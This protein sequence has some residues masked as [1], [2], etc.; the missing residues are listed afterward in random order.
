[1]EKNY[2]EETKVINKLNRIKQPTNIAFNAILLFFAL[3]CFLPFIVVVLISVTEEESIRQY[4]YQLFPKV[5][6]GQAYRFLWNERSQILNALSMSLIVTAI[7]TVVGVLL[8]TVL[9]YV[10][11]RPD[12]KLKGFLTWM[13]F[14]PMIF[15]GGMVASYV[16]NVQLLQVRNG[17]HA[18]ILPLLVSSVIVV[19][20]RTFFRTTIPDS[21][22]ESAKID[23]AGQLLIY[24]KIVLPISKPVLAT[25]AL[26]LS[27]GYWNDWFLSMLYISNTKMY[28][29][30]YLLQQ[31]VMNIEFLAKTPGVGA[32]AQEYIKSMPRESARMA[33]AVLI[34]MPIALAYP[35]FQKYF[36]SGLTIGA[37]KG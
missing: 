20:S 5:F 37:V 30:Q 10:M 6:S 18:L 29:L 2:R 28:T 14:I 7:G 9:G 4:G 13:V 19:I 27:F 16:N 36:I 12:Y 3:A 34:V 32:S 15:N 23:G 8:T 35:F 11:S 21:I 25:L 1:M 24:G 17:R 33:I 22:V 31:I 26:F